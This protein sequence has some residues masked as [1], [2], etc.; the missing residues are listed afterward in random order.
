MTKTKYFSKKQECFF[1]KCAKDDQ[2]PN[3]ND[4]RAFR[5]WTFG[6]K[7]GQTLGYEQVDVQGFVESAY[8]DEFM[9]EMHLNI[10][11]QT[12]DGV[13]VVQIV[14]DN[15]TG[16]GMHKDSVAFCRKARNIDLSQK[17]IFGV[18]QDFKNTWQGKH[19]TVVPSHLT[20]SQPGG[21]YRTQPVAKYFEYDPES[22]NSY[23]LNENDEKV[24]LP[25][26]EVTSH[27][28]KGKRD[29]SARDEVLY[30]EITDFIARVEVECKERR[31]SRPNTD[32]EVANAAVAGVV[33]GNN[34]GDELEDAPF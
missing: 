16:S 2:D 23:C 34:D 8:T 26:V 21:Q 29:T 31:E 9:D 6:D 30:K 13:Q 4:G 11:L 27:M 3:I 32:A 24:F 22:K 20:I 25:E 12:P 28:G 17:V 14:L 19:G 10:G 1:A 7:Q 33:T 18:F 15:G 5:Q